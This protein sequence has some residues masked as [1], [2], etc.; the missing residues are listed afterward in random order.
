MEP[1][2]N[3]TPDILEQ[4]PVI[5]TLGLVTGAL[6]VSGATLALTSFGAIQAQTGGYIPPQ[7]V[8]AMIGGTGLG[9]VGLGLFLALV[10]YLRKKPRHTRVC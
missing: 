10:L 2:D 7:T 4:T 6:V 9:L 5:V 8:W 1:Q 3:N